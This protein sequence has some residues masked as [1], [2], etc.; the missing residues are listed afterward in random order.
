MI[1]EYGWLFN[2]QKK[3]PQLNCDG[4]EDED[5]DADEDSLKKTLEE[6]LKENFMAACSK[7]KVTPSV[8]F[9][10]DIGNLKFVDAFY[11]CLDPV[12]K[13]NPVALQSW[14]LDR[15]NQIK[16]QREA[17]SFCLH[18]PDPITKA[19]L[20]Y[21]G[22]SVFEEFHK[23]FWYTKGQMSNCGNTL[24]FE[25]VNYGGLF[26]AFWTTILSLSNHNLDEVR[27]PFTEQLQLL[28]SQGMQILATKGPESPQKVVPVA[29]PPSVQATALPQPPPPPRFEA[30]GVS[31]QAGGLGSFCGVGT[32]FSSSPSGSYGGYTMSGSAH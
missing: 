3:S 2:D 16:D 32:G 23:D 12:I 27:I 5:E 14:K 10:Q 24:C 26:K 6:N 13:D 18:E 8:D 29:I 1:K 22:N 4:A 30:T 15:F 31:S 11:R 28:H 7:L 19:V 17:S 9:N 20:R 21:F 25:A